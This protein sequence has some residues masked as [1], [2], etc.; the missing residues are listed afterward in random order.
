[1]LL[2]VAGMHSHIHA[3]KPGVRDSAELKVQRASIA[4][5]TLVSY[6]DPFRSG[7]EGL[8]RI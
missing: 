4:L 6:P 7:K 2:K 3:Q 5:C 1:M 8:A